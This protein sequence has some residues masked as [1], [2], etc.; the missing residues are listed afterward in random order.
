MKNLVNNCNCLKIISSK[1]TE[2]ARN[3]RKEQQHKS[4]IL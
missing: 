1:D 2:E 4:Y 3:A